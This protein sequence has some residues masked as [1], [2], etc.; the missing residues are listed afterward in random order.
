VVT[1]TPPVPFAGLSSSY[2]VLREYALPL[3]EVLADADDQT[4]GHI[5]ALVRAAL[6]HLEEGR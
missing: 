2:T 3:G 1:H 5:E 6:Q 4:V